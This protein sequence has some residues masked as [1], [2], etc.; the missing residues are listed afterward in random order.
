MEFVFWMG[1]PANQKRIPSS[2]L[3]A[4]TLNCNCKSFDI[5]MLTKKLTTRLRDDDALLSPSRLVKVQV[6]AIKLFEE[7]CN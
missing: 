2:S 1:L 7:V 5:W 3:A 4:N 6:P